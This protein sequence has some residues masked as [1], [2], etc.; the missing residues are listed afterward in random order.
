M[1]DAERHHHAG[2]PFC[3][4][5]V[6]LQQVNVGVPQSGDGEGPAPVDHARAGVGWNVARRN[7]R[8]DQPA[9]NTQGVMALNTGADRIDDVD[10]A[11]PDVGSALVRWERSVPRTHTE[12]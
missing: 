6:A 9:G 5:V 7:D 1:R 12:Q 2:V 3:Y 10:V 4:R 11:N 8:L